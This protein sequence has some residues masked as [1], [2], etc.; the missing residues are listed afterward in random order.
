MSAN[1]ELKHG[2]VYTDSDGYTRVLLESTSGVWFKIAFTPDGTSYMYDNF[3]SKPYCPI[4]SVYRFN[5]VDIISN[6]LKD[7]HEHSD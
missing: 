2:D 6:I 1:G 5:L 4:D 3:S 7:D